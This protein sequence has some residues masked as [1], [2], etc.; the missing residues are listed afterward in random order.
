[1][2]YQVQ[3][4]QVVNIQIRQ[5]QGT[6]ELFRIRYGGTYL[7]QDSL[8]QYGVRYVALIDG[9]AIRI[10]CTIGKGYRFRHVAGIIFQN[11]VNYS[12]VAR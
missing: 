7:I 11:N 3:T 9:A 1:M 8:A 12:V 6:G 4:S 5:I 2:G 10:S